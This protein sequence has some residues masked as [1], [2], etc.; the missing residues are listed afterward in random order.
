M[1]SFEQ[2]HIDKLRAY[3]PECMVLLKRN[4]A[5]PLAD[6]CRIAA[7]GAG[8]RDTVKGGT[9]SGE[10]NSRYFVSV[11][12][13]LEDAGFTIT[14]K[15]WSDRYA[16]FLAQ[17]KADFRA[18]IKRKAKAQKINPIA[19]SMGAVLKQ[20]D[21]QIELDLSADA[22]IYVVSRLSGE[23][24]D[25]L[26][27][28]GDFKLNDSELRDILALDAAYDKFMLVINAGGPVDLTE[29]AQVGNILVMSQLGVEGGAALA[30][31][32]L[33]KSYPSGKLA[34]TWSAYED[35]CDLGDFA[36][37]DD[38]RY[39]EGIYVGYR[40]FDTVGKKPLFPFGF[41]L[42]YTDFALDEMVCEA[43]GT[44]LKLSAR[45]A[46]AG[47]FAGKETLQVYVSC[48]AGRLDRELKSLVGFAKTPELQPGE[49]ARV[50]VSFDVRDLA[51]YDAASACFVLEPGAYVISAGTSS[52]NAEPCAYFELDREYTVRQVRNLFG[53]P[54]FEDLQLGENERVAVASPEAPAFAS[55][56][57]LEVD[58]GSAEV[59]VPAY[60]FADG[61]VTLEELCPDAAAWL[62]SLTDEELAFLNIGAFDPKGG[63]LSVIGNASQSVAGAAG[64]SC[65]RFAGK[66][67]RPL[68]M[69]D[70]PAG[71]RLARQFYVDGKGVHAVGLSIPESVLDVLPGPA[72]WFMMRPPKLKKGVVMQEQFTTA[73]PIATAIAQ[74]FNLE[75]AQMCGD[76]VGTEMEAF[77]V[78]LWLAPALNIHR[79]VLCGRNFEYYS[80][81]PLV[82]GKFAAALTRG[83]QAHAGKGV[84]LKHY[85]ANNQETNR[86]ANNSVVSERVLREIYLRGFE[87]CVREAAP[88]AV[89]T[90]YN[91]INGVHTSELRDL[92]VALRDEFGFDG[93][94]M[95]DWVVGGEFLTGK[96][97]HPA[98]DPA[99]VAAAGCSLFM[100]GSKGDYDKLLA[101]LAAGRVSREDL[102]IN[103][104]FLLRQVKR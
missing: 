36:E 41:G 16:A 20:L 90:S 48:P 30:D 3:L 83:V 89:M 44:E 26:P 71:L 98:P 43:G 42:G 57:R 55:L 47:P 6:P 49:A 70:G 104:A 2:E 87:V 5:F 94:I 22:A 76:I 56:P 40:Y 58:L 97:K 54:D 88:R 74:S 68:V 84:T 81:D 4:G 65:S 50:S 10:V 21:Y 101:G 24:S 103:A 102:L 23:G 1:Q 79:N 92:T 60:R 9:G 93:V 25:R 85:A 75:F 99:K 96:T 45:I 91:L 18:E 8:V 11:E 51:A 73:L 72:K 19:A 27:E 31:V 32:L 17:A 7:F 61:E 29:V 63:M 37:R 28:K 33:G 12:Q 100:P 52:A 59:E 62:G 53:T 77:K 67:L 46:N 66:G 38:T 86:Y 39:R 15:D 80:E 35:Y 13:G 69:A 95:T 78:D 64:E 34:T 82:S 14:N